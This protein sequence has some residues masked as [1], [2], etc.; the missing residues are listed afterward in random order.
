MEMKEGSQFMKLA[1]TTED[2]QSP[3]ERHRPLVRTIFVL[4]RR[5]STYGFRVGS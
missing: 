5:P 3:L 2:E 1:R 4:A